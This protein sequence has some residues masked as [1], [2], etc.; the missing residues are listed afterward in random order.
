MENMSVETR[1][2]TE[3]MRH[4]PP[5][6]ELRDRVGKLFRHRTMLA[7]AILE[8]LPEGDPVREDLEEG[9]SEVASWLER[10][11]D[12]ARRTRQPQAHDTV[13]PMTRVRGALDAATE[14]LSRL[15]GDQFRRRAPFHQFETSGAESIR[16]CVLAAGYALNR[17]LETLQD[18]D[19]DIWWKLH[20]P[21]PPE[22]QRL[23]S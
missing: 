21:S 23:I 16:S 17:L 7:I 5:A 11:T 20:D 18:A 1:G 22:P 8:R 10:V 4:I 19:P 9:L 3:P 6:E 13:A 12:A 15:E 2:T 14:A